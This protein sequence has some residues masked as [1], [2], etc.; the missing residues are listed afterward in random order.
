MR[1]HRSFL[2]VT[3]ALVGVVGLTAQGGAQTSEAA[4]IQGQDCAAEVQRALAE[5]QSHREWPQVRAAIEPMSEKAI[6]A[7]RTGEGNCYAV[8]IGM[9]RYLVDNDVAIAGFT[10][11]ESMAATEQSYVA[12]TA[13]STAG[14]RT[15]VQVQTKPAQV[16][17]QQRASDVTVEEE[18]T[19]VAV[20]QRSAEVSVT[21]PQAEVNVAAPKSRVQVQQPEAQV[22]VD[23]ARPQVSVQQ[24][25][26]DV[27]VTQ[28]EPEI[29]VEQSRPQVAINQPA[30]K[31]QIKQFKPEVKIVQPEP[32]IRVEQ[33][34]PVVSVQQ[35]Q[36]EVVV[37]QAKPQVT[38]AQAKPTV[39][40]EEAKPQVQVTQRKPEVSVQQQEAAVHVEQARAEV[41]VS[42]A[43]PQI[44]VNQA[45]PQVDVQQ[46]KPS[47]SVS[48]RKAQVDVST[49]RAQVSVDQE[50]GAEVG[51]RTAQVGETVA[52]EQPAGRIQVAIAEAGADQLTAIAADAILVRE[53]EFAFD[54]AQVRSGADEVLRDVA[55]VQRESGDAMVLLTG[56]TDKVGDRGYN[57][58]LSERRVSA[59]AQALNRTGIDD[60]WI[61]TRHFGEQNPEEATSGR[62]EHNRRVEIRVIPAEFLARA[63]ARG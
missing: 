27:T 50:R 57:Q 42:Q 46:G 33:K 21:Q 19:Q 49:E 51:M 8:L 5:V 13:G 39:V 31:V 53:V 20:S 37:E 40:V 45:A 41:E 58:K 1:F 63:Q 34:K 15:E 26:P 18:P 59:V 3:T 56:Y 61:R 17:V 7:A 43:R 9:Q 25:A 6:S 55:R 52:V 2:A 11:A 23:A 10:D 12:A 60:T 54:K 4:R 36:P 16:G 14:A 62:S 38:V 29:A 35:P 24:P 28:P 32:N 44:E 48:Q 30:P 47:V 22:Q